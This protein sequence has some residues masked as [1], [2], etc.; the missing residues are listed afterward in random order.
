PTR[1][2]CLDVFVRG[3]YDV[4]PNEVKSVI[5]RALEGEAMIAPGHAPEV[6]L[7][8]FA[9]SWMTYRVR[10][11]TTDFDRDDRVR[12]HVRSRVYY[13]FHRHG[14]HFPVPV[15][16]TAEPRRPT[17]APAVDHVTALEDVEIL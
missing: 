3:G 1:E 11:W 5:V 17:A 9:D 10:V 13:A 8:E 2:T 14:I 6:L 15:Q 12:D 4:A 7:F 16:L